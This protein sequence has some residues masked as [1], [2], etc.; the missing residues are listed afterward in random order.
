MWLGMVSYGLYL[1]HP[2]VPE[3][4]LQLL[5]FLGLSRADWGVYFIRMPLM[6]AM[7]LALVTASFYLWERPI[8]SYR[9]LLA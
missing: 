7:L 3:L 9:R 6:T 4:Y 1:I 8:R 5:S 2:F